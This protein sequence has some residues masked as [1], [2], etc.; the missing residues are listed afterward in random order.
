M[1]H[2]TFLPWWGMTKVKFATAT[3]EGPALT[4]WKYKVAT[5]GLETVNQMPWVEMK[6]LMTIEFCLI[7]EIQRTKH[8]TVK[9][10]HVKIDAYIQGLFD[11][12]KGEVTSSRPA[13]L[14]EA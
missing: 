11:H 14:N 1:L 9:P 13:N 12:I 4:W 10:E 5:I 8:E 7:E 3:L 2:L 6:Q